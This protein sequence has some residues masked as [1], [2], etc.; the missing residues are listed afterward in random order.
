MELPSNKPSPFS[1]QPSKTP[2]KV[3]ETPPKKQSEPGFFGEEGIKRSEFTRKFVKESGKVPGTSRY[4]SKQQ[5]EALVSK[6]D[7]RLGDTITEKDVRDSIRKTRKEIRYKDSWDPVRKEAE[8]T[9][10]ILEE[11][12]KGKN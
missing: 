1:R 12:L 4:L 2:R 8:D 11:K 3:S 6:F 9:I 7:K 10:K 5:R